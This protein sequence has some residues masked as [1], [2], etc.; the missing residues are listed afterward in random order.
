MWGGGKS[1]QELK[2]ELGDATDIIQITVDR[3]T[4]NSSQK[5][6]KNIGEPLLSPT[7]GATF[8]VV[9]LLNCQTEYLPDGVDPT[10]KE[11]YLSNEDF[12]LI[13]GV[14]RV[15]FYSVPTWKQQNLKK[16]TGLF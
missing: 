7:I 4:Y 3:T 6:S 5:N 14:S 10:K 8:P 1:Y 2:A 13:L 9:K 15:E 12:A 11:E 16:E